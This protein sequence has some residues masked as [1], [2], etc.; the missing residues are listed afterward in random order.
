MTTSETK[1]T[2]DPTV[3]PALTAIHHVGITATDVEASAAWHERVLGFQH[4]FEER[5]YRSDAGGYTIVLGPLTHPLV[6]GSIITQRTRGTPSI[7]PA[8]ASTTCPSRWHQWILCTHGGRISRDRGYPTPACTPWRAS[9][10]R[11]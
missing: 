6:S 7:Q 3:Q 1:A 4:Q 5:H 11:W 10:C 8:R 9:R 2:S